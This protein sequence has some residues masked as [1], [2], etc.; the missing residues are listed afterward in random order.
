MVAN[1]IGW[2]QRKATAAD[3]VASFLLVVRVEIGVVR[4]VVRCALV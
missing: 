1:S 2:L 3:V 4:E